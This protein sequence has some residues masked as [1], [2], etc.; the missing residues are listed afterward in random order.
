MNKNIIVQSDF[1]AEKKATNF[2]GGY[3]THPA[4]H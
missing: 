1:T 2:H 3:G 4:S